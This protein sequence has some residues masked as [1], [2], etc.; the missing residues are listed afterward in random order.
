MKMFENLGEKAKEK[1]Q[2]IEFVE[3][4]T[5]DVETQNLLLESISGEKNP[6]NWV[7]PFDSTEDMF[8]HFDREMQK[9]G[10]FLN[11]ETGYYEKKA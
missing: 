8:D 2:D 7:G 11:K 10:Y 4:I 6:D 1:L 5:T 9:D 3:S